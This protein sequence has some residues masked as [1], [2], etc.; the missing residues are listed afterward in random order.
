MTTT[1]AT[2]PERV[3]AARWRRRLDLAL[4]IAVGIVLGLAVI[5][6][7]VFLGEA[8][9]IDTPRIKGVDT[10]KRQ[11]PPPGQAKSEPAP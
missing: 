3:G 11:A 2:E 8:G 7:F 5:S 9:S 4:G 10:G 6:A 1:P